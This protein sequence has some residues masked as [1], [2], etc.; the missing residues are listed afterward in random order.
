[1]TLG[2]PGES[3]SRPFYQLALACDGVQGIYHLNDGDAG[4]NQVLDAVAIGHDLHHG[5][6]GQAHGRA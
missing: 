2:P 3:A 5:K 4:V 1:M 6:L